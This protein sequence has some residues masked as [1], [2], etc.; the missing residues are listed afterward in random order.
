MIYNKLKELQQQNNLTNKEVAESI[1]RS[2]QWYSDIFTSKSLKIED[3]KLLAKLFKVDMK[4]F[5]EDSYKDGDTVYDPGMH[6][7]YNQN[8]NE[9]VSLNRRSLETLLDLTM[10]LKTSREE[11]KNLLVEIDI[12]K[13]ELNDCKSN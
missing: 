3:L 2:R 4:V 10:Q 7:E 8:I 1:G 5:F 12:L 11:N 13:R 6:N 9:L